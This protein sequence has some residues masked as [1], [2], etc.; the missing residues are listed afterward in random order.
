M[1]MDLCCKTIPVLQ[2]E[3]VEY[4]DYLIGYIVAFRWDLIVLWRGGSYS[5]IAY[6]QCLPPDAVAEVVSGWCFLSREAVASCQQSW[7]FGKL[8][9]CSEA[10]LIYDHSLVA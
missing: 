10:D 2:S 3:A 8:E 6:Y 4:L 9:V 1:P 7:A 5:S